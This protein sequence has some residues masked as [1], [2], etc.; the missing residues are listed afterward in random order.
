[1]VAY[2]KKQEGSEGFHQILDFLNAS[3]ISNMK[4]GTK[5]F[6]GEDISLFPTIIVQGQTVQGEGSTHPVESHYTPIIAPST[7]QQLISQTYRRTTRQGFVVPQ[8]RFPTHTYVEDEAIFFGE[9]DRMVRA[10]TTVSSLE[11]GHDIGNINRTQSMAT[12][13]ATGSLRT[14]LAGDPGCHITIRDTPNHTR[15]EM[16]FTMPNDLP[17]L[18]VNTLGSDEGSMQHKEL[19]E[20][21][22]KLSKRLTSLEKEV[23]MTKQTY[24]AAYTTLITKVKK[25]EQKLKSRPSVSKIRR[26]VISSDKEDLVDEHP[27]KQGRK[28]AE[29]DQ[30]EGIT[31]VQVDVETQGR[32]GDDMEFDTSVFEEQEVF[33]AA[34]DVTTTKKEVSTAAR[35]STA[36]TEFTTTSVA[37]ST[38]S[39][40]RSN[41]GSAA[42]TLVYIRRSAEKDKG[43][44]IM[45]E[46]EQPRKIKKRVQI[47]NTVYKEVH[48]F[49]PIG[50][51]VE[52]ERTKRAE[53]DELSQEE[54]QQMMIIVPEQ[55]MNVEALQT[56]DD[57]EKLWSLV[58]EKFNL[59]ELID[60]KERVLWVE[61]KRIF[62]P[63]TG[64][65]IYMLVEREYPLLRGTLT[66]MLVAKLLVEQDNEMSRELL[67]KIVMQAERPRR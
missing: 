30:D 7:S 36:G 64:M 54:L 3:H 31:L 8:P 52:S 32:Y 10:A 35:V 15:S 2:L 53:A 65:D 16:V 28:I 40:T 18:R 33:L 25:L 19:M 29:I 20:L 22:T 4:R 39:P 17:L 51:E 37:V 42:K 41:D 61:L 6:T 13:P 59:T 21:C 1:M 49:V 5:G 34:K 38:A 27:S 24:G 47:F 23:K 11:A 12:P 48:T 63:Y 56:E 60:D 14:S 9:N 26:L 67:R 55:G 66:L 44:S 57:L 45:Q 50:T 62:E 43:K 46:F 58:K